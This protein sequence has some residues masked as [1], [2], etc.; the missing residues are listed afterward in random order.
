[1]RSIVE[2]CTRG[3]VDIVKFKVL[4]D[5]NFAKT[6]R[7]SLRKAWEAGSHDKHSHPD[8]DGSMQSRPPTVEIIDDDLGR[9]GGGIARPG[10]E[11]LLAAICDG[12]VGAVLAIEASR[13]ARNGRDWHTLMPDR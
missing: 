9:S 11:R 10:F 3:W 1:M 2:S 7:K 8:H 6:E 13:L 12:R 5:V 4:N